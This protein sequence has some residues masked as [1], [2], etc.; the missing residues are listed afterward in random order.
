MDPLTQGLLGAALPQA[1]CK[2][3]QVRRATWI[4]LLGGMAPDADVFIRSAA[5]PLLA[6]QYH[7]HFTHSLIFIPVGGLIV[8]TLVWL[9]ARRRL[10]FG[11]VCTFATLG[12]ATHA[13]LDACT[14]YGT[15][16]LWPFSDMRVAW[17]NVAVVDFFLT[18][19]LGILVFLAMKRRR[20]QWARIGLVFVLAYLSLGVVQRERAESVLR[21]LAAERGH[22]P[23]ELSA[24]PTLFNLILFR[25]IYTTEDRFHVDGIRVGFF[26]APMIIEGQSVKRFSTEADLPNLPEDS[27]LAKDIARFAHFSDGYLARHP[28]KPGVVGD[29]RYSML[30]QSLEPLWGITIR[31]DRPDEHVPF[32]NFRD[33]AEEKGPLFFKMVMGRQPVK[34]EAPLP[35]SP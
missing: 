29:I 1:V 11:Q 32:D 30:P 26:S 22:T 5:D 7:R 20:P 2:Q 33:N 9:L 25:G 23:L 34:P 28:T 15:Q 8:A 14:S 19:P 24:K 13:V 6:I 35:T 17:N 18:V 16:L 4:G 10:P 12:Y 21:K 27:V 3:E 31:P